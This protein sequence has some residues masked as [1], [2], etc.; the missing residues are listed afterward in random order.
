MS[1]SWTQDQIVSVLNN[2][3]NSRSNFVYE[4][5]ILVST[6]SGEGN[7]N[8]FWAAVR[9]PRYSPN[10]C[11]FI[12]RMHIRSKPPWRTL[13]IQFGLPRLS[14]ASGIL[15]RQIP[16]YRRSPR[17]MDSSTGGL[18]TFI[19]ISTASQLSRYLY[20]DIHR[21]A[22]VAANLTTDTDVAYQTAIKQRTGP[23]VMCESFIRL[24]LCC[25]CGH[26]TPSCESA[27]SPWQFKNLGGDQDW[28]EQS[29]YLWMYR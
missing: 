16:C 2:N 15:L 5:D 25:I 1:F 12:K 19:M 18:G 22:D 14:L 24:A 11:Q 7:G 3:I 10:L 17:L 29:D 9:M 20:T 13:G 8:D 4:G 6:F 21:P 26:L 23:Y 28:V 27:V